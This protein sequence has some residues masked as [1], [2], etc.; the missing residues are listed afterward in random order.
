MSKLINKFF[1]DDERARTIIAAVGLIGGLIV[2]V[3]FFLSYWLM[4]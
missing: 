1:E 3:L 4:R 2:T